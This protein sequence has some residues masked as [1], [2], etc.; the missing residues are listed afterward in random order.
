MTPYFHA[1]EHV[2]LAVN[3]LLPVMTA[4]EA[5]TRPRLE[6]T[7]PETLTNALREAQ[8][9]L[10]VA[11]RQLA[12]AEAVFHCTDVAALEAETKPARPPLGPSR[13]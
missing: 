5:F 7:P 1:L 13:N 3:H 6:A 11:S 4:L 2:S 10:A 12:F 8:I 9:E